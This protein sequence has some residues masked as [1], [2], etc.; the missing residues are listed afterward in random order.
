[1]STLST[2]KEVVRGYA[3]TVNNVWNK[4]RQ[5]R[6]LHQC[7]L[8]QA[9]NLQTPVVTEEATP[10]V[11]CDPSLVG[12][13]VR[14]PQEAQAMCRNSPMTREDMA[15]FP[16][17]AHFRRPVVHTHTIHQFQSQCGILDPH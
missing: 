11:S 2:R 17:R 13:V 10:C 6:W 4:R 3:T 8:T 12:M 15:L 14:R 1:V 7:H 9:S 16:G 5:R